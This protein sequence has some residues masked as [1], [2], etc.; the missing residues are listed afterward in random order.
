MSEESPAQAKRNGTSA[1]LALCLALAPMAAVARDRAPLPSEDAM[2]P[3]PSQG[4]GF[5]RIPGTATCLRVS[6]RVAVDAGAGRAAAPVRG[7]LSIDTRSPSE[8]GPV[9]SFLR[10]GPGAP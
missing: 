7:R 2:E 6:G 9:R 10:I 1:L 3:C 8:F 5:A 4:P